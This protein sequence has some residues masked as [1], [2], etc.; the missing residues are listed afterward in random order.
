ML[1]PTRFGTDTTVIIFGENSVAIAAEA[2]KF[3]AASA[4]VCD[5]DA[6]GEYRLE[7][8]AALLSNLVN[9]YQPTA[10]VSVATS[11]AD[12]SC[13]PA[14]PPTAKAASSPR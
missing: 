12:A 13:S 10:V 5:A 11:Q 14:P 4:I 6:M 1:S 9:E 8:F 3:G 7:S 2:G